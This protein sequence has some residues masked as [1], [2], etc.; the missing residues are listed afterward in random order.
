[1]AVRK[2]D[3]TRFLRGH[4]LAGRRIWEEQARRLPELSASEALSEYEDLCR[5]WYRTPQAPE[6]DLERLTWLLRL[7]GIFAL[8]DR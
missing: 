2:E 5:I 1:M 7:R 8:Q 3:L 4:D 6:V